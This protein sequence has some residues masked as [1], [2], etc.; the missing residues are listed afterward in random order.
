MKKFSNKF[1]A[2]LMIA[3]SCAVSCKKK[4]DPAP[5]ESTGPTELSGSLTTQTLDASK[6]YLLVGQVFVNDGQ[7][8]TIP[9]GTTIMGDKG[10]K[11]LLVIN[12]GGKIMAEGTAANPI[13]FTS[14][15]AVGERDK[16]DWGGVIILGRA[17]CNQNGPAIEGVSPAVTYGT[18]QSSANDTENS[19]IMKYVRIEYAGIALSP[20]NETNSLTMGAVGSG[21]TLENIQVSFGG[22]DGF[23]WFGGTANAKNLIS[24]GT[25]DDDFDC[26]FGYSGT[27]QHAVAIRD[28]FAADQSGSNAFECDN[29]A[30]GNDVQPY[31]SAVFSN[32]TVLGPMYDSTKSISGNY[33]HAMHLRRR[34]AVSIFNSVIAGYPTGF[35]LYG[36]STE[37][38]YITNLNGVVNDN[39]LI[40]FSKGTAAAIPYQS[41]TANAAKNYWEA[42]NDIALTV[43]NSST[44]LNAVGLDVN[45]FYGK[46]SPY[47]ANPDFGT[48]GVT[49]T[50]AT[51]GDFSHAKL[52]TF[53][54]TTYRGAFGGNDWTDGWSNFDPQNTVY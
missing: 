18:F 30:G 29:D 47:P 23:E 7:V 51:G 21:T 6:T 49:G 1:L 2:V 12:V 38:Q 22:D 20:N 42:S 25:W 15:R 53:T 3:V 11:G 19:G 14:E 8:L 13:V 10:T 4:D 48:L 52:S 39:I 5:V 28:P 24:Y 32:V 41:T 16:G 26:D 17:N 40:T 27:V 35:R 45:L 36:T 44:A 9:A 37:T 33:Q 54:S 50:S 31:T 43:S 34:T 46:T